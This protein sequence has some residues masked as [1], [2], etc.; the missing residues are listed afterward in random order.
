MDP[1]TRRERLTAT[2]RGEPVDRPAVNFYELSALR[3]DPDDPDEFNVHNDPS[4]RPL[5]QLA[6]EQTD[7]ICMRSARPVPVHKECIDELLSIERYTEDGSRFVRTTVTVVGRTLTS[8]DRRDPAVDTV[9]RLE[10]LLKDTDDLEAYLQLP[11]EMFDFAPD[12]SPLEKAEQ[13]VGDRGIVM[14]DT[15]DPMCNAASLFSMEDYLVT[16]M[17]ERKLFHRLLEKLARPMHEFSEKVSA[18]FPGHL[19]RIYGPEYAGEP[20]LPPD[21][22]KEYVVR[23]TKPIV[24][25]IGKHGGYAR[26]HMH[27]RLSSAL[28]MIVE[29]GAEGLDPIEPPDQGD[30][31]LGYVRRQY[32]K[33][34]ILF[35]NL[36]CRDI[37]N[38]PPDQFEGIV[39]KALTEGTEGD[40]KGFVLMPSSSPYGRTVTPGTLANYRTM[41]RLA[42]SFS[43]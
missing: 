25:A 19:W 23:Y 5:L 33:D 18:S 8:L 27:G 3:Q 1:M 15:S 37:E 29:M 22:F 39:A 21:L 4:W 14:V 42:T 20:F 41:V 36:E 24:E 43:R 17:T 38:M 34:L 30:V 32:G 12:L 2:L 11:D 16:A 26:I 35:G 13:L 7:L 31:E 28:P 9:W 6:N 40:G 10:H